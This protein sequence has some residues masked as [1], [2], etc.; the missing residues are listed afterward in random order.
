MGD[1]P[2]RPEHRLLVCVSPSASSARLINAAKKMATDLHAEWFAVYVE[3]NTAMMSEA[4]R[5]RAADQLRLAAE[6][7]AEVV[8]LAG[9]NVGEELARFARQRGITRIIA[10]KPGRSSWNRLGS[11]SPVDQLVRSGGEADVYVISGEAGEQREP[12]YVIR[13]DGM[14]LS[15]Y[16]SA[17]LYLVVATLVCFAMYPYFHLSNLIMVYL[18]GVTLI[19]TECGRGPAILSSLLSVLAF[20]FFFVPP[21]YSFT[22]EQVEYVVTFVVMSLVGLVI[23]PLAYRMRTDR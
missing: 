8:T 4:A 12:G 15:D 20:D 16:G 1:N 19:A 18:L 14:G 5:S 11:R 3:T 7:G 23:R 13:P 9:R 22:V 10:G 17:V 21:R 2:G 6:L